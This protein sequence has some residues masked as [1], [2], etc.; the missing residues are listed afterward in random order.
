MGARAEKTMIVLTVEMSSPDSMMV[1]QICVPRA[2]AASHWAL[3]P[4]LQGARGHAQA[5]GRQAGPARERCRTDQDVRAAV[6]EGEKPLL[7]VCEFA[8]RGDHARIGRR[9]EDHRVHRLDV[10]DPRDDAV[11]LRSVRVFMLARTRASLGLSL[12]A[13]SFLRR[14]RG[15][16]RGA[17]SAR[18]SAP[19]GKGWGAQFGAGALPVIENDLHLGSARE[20]ASAV[21]NA[22]AGAHCRALP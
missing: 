14:A 5:P 20:G 3:R 13:S 8:V 15:A 11:R 7:K 9:A 22:S 17:R 19:A 10:G 1:V 12:A 4:L 21:A 6:R 2:A 16:G 18:F